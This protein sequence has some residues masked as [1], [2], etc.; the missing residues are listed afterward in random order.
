MA[1][2]T[3]Y[4]RKHISWQSDATVREICQPLFENMDINYFS[5][6][7]SYQDSSAIM[8]QTDSAWFE[9]YYTQQYVFGPSVLN[10]GI[11]L[12]ADYTPTAQTVA[13][14]HFN[15]ANGFSIVKKHQD[16]TEF[17]VFATPNNNQYN[18]SFYLNNRDALEQFFFYFKDKANSLIKLSS[19]EKLLIPKS[20]F[21]IAKP[22]D[23]NKDKLLQAI[24]TNKYQLNL[25][26]KE[27]T[28]SKREVETL[29]QVAEGYSTKEIAR[30]LDLSPKTIARHLENIKEK[31]ACNK[32]TKIIKQAC[33]VNLF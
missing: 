6:N 14:D 29:Q 26:G 5:Y 27:I 31:F 16:C 3:E 8:L 18:F 32:S 2:Y 24:Q 17:F 33:E 20:M 10:S 15:H 30:I 4:L 7:R 25:N 21:G 12:W 28:L 22:I 11:H 13:K 1:L 9:H 23:N 19:Q